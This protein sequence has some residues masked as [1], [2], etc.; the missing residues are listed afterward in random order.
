M[1]ETPK[2]AGANVDVL[3]D[4]L[5]VIRL[6]GAV[7]FRASFGAPWSLLTAGADRLLRQFPASV[8]RLAVFHVVVRGRC[9]I[10]GPSDDDEPVETSEAVVLPRCD[11]HV[12]ADDPARPPEPTE[13]LLAGTPL[14]SLRDIEY[15]GDGEQ[16]QIL[17]G[18]L[19]CEQIAF[20]PLY[21]ALPPLFRVSLGGVRGLLEYAVRE[22]VS[23]SEG[24]A[25]ARLRVAE[26]LFVEA[27]RRY[28]ADL[29]GHETG[30]LA[31]LRD[32]VVGKALALL[33]AEP[34][35]AWTVPALASAAAV[36]RSSLNARFTQL[37]DEPPMHYL[38]R[39]RL[40]LAARQLHDQ[41]GSI[42]AIAARVGYESPAAFARAFKRRYGETPAVYRKRTRMAA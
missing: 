4:V 6:S 40:L 2:A 3:S 37:L 26:L 41:R 11:V 8:R 30:W 31:G 5:R 27:L 20:E 19:S 32:P 36:S 29:A 28:M 33:H 17:C 18:F 39:W 12:L 25:G 21:A 24:A 7:L 9:W 16:T 35:R 22:A 42:A 14:T 23:E 15:G 10:R 13:A 34:A 1:P 38:T